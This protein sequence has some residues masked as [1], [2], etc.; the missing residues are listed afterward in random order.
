MTCTLL[1]PEKVQLID[2]VLSQS[3][4]EQKYN[5]AKQAYADDKMSLAVNLLCQ[6]PSPKGTARKQGQDEQREVR[7]HLR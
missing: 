4:I 6:S 1:I 5:E 7:V 2:H 3:G